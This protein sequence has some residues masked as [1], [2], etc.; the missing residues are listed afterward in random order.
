[1]FAS[2]AVLFRL[3][4]FL[5]R[6][7]ALFLGGLLSGLNGTVTVNGCGDSLSLAAGLKRRS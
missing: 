1:L 5:L 6:A 3:V 7:E 2:F 4:P